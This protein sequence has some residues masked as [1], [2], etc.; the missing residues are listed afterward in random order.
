M[1]LC[2]PLLNYF[3][4]I[5]FLSLY[6]GTVP[7]DNSKAVSYSSYIIAQLCPTVCDSWTAAH[8]SPLPMFS[9]EEY[10]NSLPFPPPG[11]RLN[12]RIKSPSLAAPAMAGRFFTTESSGKP[13]CILNDSL[14][15]FFNFSC[16]LLVFNKKILS[17]FSKTTKLAY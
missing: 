12:S 11:D 5:I 15:L 8:Q 1:Q 13:N 16:I 14:K 10:W 9:R 3:Q 4:I 17:N 6:K 2:L 7:P